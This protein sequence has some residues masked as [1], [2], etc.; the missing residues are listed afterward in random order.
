MA[1]YNKII[2]NVINL[3]NNIFSLNYDKND[4]I[5]GIHKIFFGIL[6]NIGI[7]KTYKSKFDFYSKNIDNFYFSTRL[8]ERE[9]FILLF[10]KIQKIYYTLNKF[11]YLYKYRKAKLIVDTDLQLNKIVENEQ[12]ILCIYH[13]NAKYL[14]TIQDILKLIYI[15]LTNTF[16]FFSE[17]ISI[18]N[19]YNN[20]PFSKSIL[21]YIYYYLITNAKI[22]FIKT[23]HLDIFLKFKECNFN[24]TKFVNNYEYILKEYGIKNFLNNSTKQ[25]II[26]QIKLMINNFNNTTNKGIYI[27]DEFPKDEL[28]RIMKPYLYLKLMSIYSLISKNKIHA[29]NKLYK[30]LRE[31]QNYNPKFG[32]K[33]FKFKNIIQNGK[34]KKVISGF[35][36]DMKYKK[37]NT[38]EIQHFMNNHLNY[39]YDI[40]YEEEIEEPQIRFNFYTHLVIDTPLINNINNEEDYE[41]DIEEDYEEDTEEYDDGDTQEYDEEENDEQEN[42]DEEDDELV[43]EEY[44]M[45]SIS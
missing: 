12:N 5:S 41:E 23:E 40:S 26:D 43:E 9:E 3:D 18:K 42:Y 2:N 44:E 20:I 45:D 25:I 31:F 36:F 28:I 37:F 30:K 19:P 27:S 33:I 10:N 29:K 34:I 35:V 38:Y 15:S 11:V 14:F 1:T 7:Y 21:Y 24:M 39:K 22:R 4:K 17:P 13:V 6:L 32:R 8:V 16:S